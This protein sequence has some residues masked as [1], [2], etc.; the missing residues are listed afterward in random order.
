MVGDKDV[1]A[2]LSMLPTSATYYFTQAKIPRSLNA[3]TLKM[4]ALNFG[5]CGETYPT[6]SD[7][8]KAAVCDADSNDFIFVGGSSFVVADLLSEGHYKLNE[9]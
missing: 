7:A 1:D 5:L 9:I 8:L 3:E 2:V 4:H 6:V